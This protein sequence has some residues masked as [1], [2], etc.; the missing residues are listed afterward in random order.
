MAEEWQN[1]MA[2]TPVN[3][4]Y[5]NTADSLNELLPAFS[6]V[7]DGTYVPWSTENAV[8]QSGSSPSAST[9]ATNN[10]YVPWSTENSIDSG[11][12]DNTLGKKDDTFIGKALSF[13]RDDIFGF[14][15][16]PQNTDP[17]KNDFAKGLMGAGV[18]A[19]AGAGKAYSDTRKL[20]QDREL[21]QQKIDIERQLAESQ[22]NLL[23]Q[24]LANQNFDGLK[25]ASNKSP[26]GLIGIP[27]VVSPVTRRVA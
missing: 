8:D 5:G 3:Y 2:S 7:F 25:I 20:N 26:T 10:T 19:I 12:R 9:D 17:N 4:D 13:V 24:R 16:N 23:K 14:D 22:A 6:P 27:A 11:A 1:D 18:A 21:T 15:T